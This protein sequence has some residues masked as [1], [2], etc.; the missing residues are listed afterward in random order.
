MLPTGDILCYNQGS[1]D[2]A[3]EERPMFRTVS[4]PF[5]TKIEESARFFCLALRVNYFNN[6]IM[7]TTN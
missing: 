1:V 2:L 7:L 6:A 4:L 5:L 3:I